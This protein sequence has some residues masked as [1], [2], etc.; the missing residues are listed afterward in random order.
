[1]SCDR[2]E[3]FSLEKREVLMRRPL[4]DRHYSS[5]LGYTV[6]SQTRSLRRTPHRFHPPLKN[7]RT[8]VRLIMNRLARDNCHP[9]SLC[10]TRRLSRSYRGRHFNV[11]FV[12]AAVPKH[13]SHAPVYTTIVLRDRHRQLV[14]VAVR[15]V[16]AKKPD[17]EEGTP[18]PLL[19]GRTLLGR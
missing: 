16:R 4:S 13:P 17:D 14:S 2:T 19:R 1:M 3:P 7:C 11:P 8:R 9:R 5:Y 10:K 12:L 6:W 18:V 15:A